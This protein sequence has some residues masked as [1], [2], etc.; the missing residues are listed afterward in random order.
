MA[1][2]KLFV[3][4][5]AVPKLD[6]IALRG[7]PVSK[8]QLEAVYRAHKS[9]GRGIKAVK[10]GESGAARKRPEPKKEAGMRES[11]SL[12]QLNSASYGK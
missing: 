1:L 7:N 9:G 10:P 12:E 8:M 5:N 11:P 6:R 3:D 4:K 2:V